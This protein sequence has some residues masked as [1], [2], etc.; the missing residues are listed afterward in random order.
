MKCVGRHPPLPKKPM[1]IYEV[2]KYFKKAQT[3]FSIIYY[4]LSHCLEY[5]LILDLERQVS[6][7]LEIFS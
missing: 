3:C 4:I 7:L 5:T 2:S 1:L 6:T